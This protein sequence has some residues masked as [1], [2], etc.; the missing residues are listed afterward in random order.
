MITRSELMHAIAMAIQDGQDLYIDSYAKSSATPE[1]FYYLEGGENVSGYTLLLSTRTFISHCI[2]GESIGEPADDGLICAQDIQNGWDESAPMPSLQQIREYVDACD[3]NNNFEDMIDELKCYD[4]LPHH[5]GSS[6]SY[7]LTLDESEDNGESVAMTCTLT[8][9]DGATVGTYKLINELAD[10]EFGLWEVETLSG[11][12]WDDVTGMYTDRSRTIECAEDNDE[13]DRCYR[14][15]SIVIRITLP[16]CIAGLTDEET[17]ALYIAHEQ[18][19]AVAAAAHMART[20]AQPYTLSRS[21]E[22]LNMLIYIAAGEPD[23]IDRCFVQAYDDEDAARVIHYPA[24]DVVR[25]E[26]RNAEEYLRTV[27]MLSGRTPD[28][29]ESDEGTIWNYYNA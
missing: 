2:Y 7:T 24:R 3:I 9:A 14:R 6:L 13:L 20:A 28:D 15:G 8:R 21:V 25:A 17:R 22:L 10:D 18:R 29:A 26:G 4:V 19:D 23:A 16:F 27:S 1:D 5:E 12:A 11:P